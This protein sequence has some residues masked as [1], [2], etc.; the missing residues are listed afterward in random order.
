MNKLFN[1]AII[2]LLLVFNIGCSDD[3]QLDVILGADK[4]ELSFLAKDEPQMVTLSCNTDWIAKSDKSWCKVNPASGNGEGVLTVEVDENT[5]TEILNAVITLLAG[6]KSVEIKVKQGTGGVY[7][8]KLPDFTE[9]FVYNVKNGDT[10]I[11]ELCKEPVP[12]GAA[13]V[14]TLYLL[15]EGGKYPVDGYVVDNGG[16]IKYDGSGYTPG[17]DI[18]TAE[19]VFL[20]KGQLQTSAELAVP[21]T[22]E[23]ELLADSDDNTYMITKIGANYWMAENL[24]TTSYRDGIMPVDFIRDLDIWKTYQSGAYG[25]YDNDEANKDIYGALYNGEAAYSNRN[26]APTGWHIPTIE[27]W[28][29][30]FTFIGGET[31]DGYYFDK[32]GPKVKAISDLWVDANPEPATNVTGLSILPGGALLDSWEGSDIGYVLGHRYIGSWAYY[33]AKPGISDYEK[34]F[35]N[36]RVDGMTAGIYSGYANMNEGYAIRCVKDVQK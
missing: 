35:W 13:A 28:S 20:V 27:E 31:T 8:I 1:L 3:N 34:D 26:L 32:V 10:K 24:K 19:S 22:V 14:V 21:L 2:L 30:M 23:P 12:G 17:T 25:W 7:E 4:S 9:S 36:V 11:A 15:E 18:N 5:G 16:S 33:W 6:D 29:D